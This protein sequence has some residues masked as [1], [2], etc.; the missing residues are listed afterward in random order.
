M[1][2]LHTEEWTKREGTK[3]NLS[4][5]SDG[6][7]PK[8]TR[9]E[10]GHMGEDEHVPSTRTPLL[11]RPVSTLVRRWWRPWLSVRLFWPSTGR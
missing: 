2:R 5:L 7:I 11:P 8:H 3:V 6:S 9:E 4:V 10:E 1:T